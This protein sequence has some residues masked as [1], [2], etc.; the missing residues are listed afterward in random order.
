[1]AWKGNSLVG[2]GVYMSLTRSEIPICL[3]S[4]AT[5]LQTDQSFNSGEIVAFLSFNLCHHHNRG[6]YVYKL[7][8]YSGSAKEFV[9]PYHAWTYALD[10]K[11]T[12]AKRLRKIENFSGEILNIYSP[13]PLV[14]KRL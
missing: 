7:C 5:L 1:M 9:C 13:E 11:L 8:F 12:Q 3:P 10:G 14:A 4:I 6:P 2:C